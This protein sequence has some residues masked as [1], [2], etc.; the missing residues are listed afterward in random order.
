VRYER[1]RVEML[2]NALGLAHEAPALWADFEERWGEGRLAFEAFDRRFVTFPWQL[3]AQSFYRTC[4]DNPWMTLRSWFRN[5]EGT[6]I[7]KWYVRYLTAFHQQATG[8]ALFVDRLPEVQKTRPLGMIFPFQHIHGGLILHNGSPASRKPRFVFSALGPGDDGDGNMVP[9]AMKCCIEPYS[10]WLAAVA[11][12]GWTPETPL[13]VAPPPP[14]AV[15]ARAGAWVEPWMMGSC[16]GVGPDSM[17]LAWLWRLLTAELPW[18]YERRFLGRDRG[19][20]CVVAT[21]KEIAGELR[22]LRERQVRSALASLRTKG[23]VTTEGTRI[24][25]TTKALEASSGQPES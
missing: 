15:R 7:W 13:A 12:S 14:R 24:S 3:V 22:P 1:E 6:F 23:L 2:L 8:K 19:Q 21:H 17:V 10:A 5:F 9:V 4:A 18:P 20:R 11:S 16:G 25:L